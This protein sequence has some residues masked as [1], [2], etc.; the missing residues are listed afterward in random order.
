MHKRLAAFLNARAASQFDKFGG[1][2]TGDT[3]NLK[4][5]DMIAWGVSQSGPPPTGGGTTDDDDVHWNQETYVE[6]AVANDVREFFRVYSRYTKHLS[7]S[8][9]KKEQREQE[10]VAVRDAA[11]LGR[12]SPAPRER[13]QDRGTPSPSPTGISRTTSPGL[14]TEFDF[15]GFNTF[16]HAAAH[17]AQNDKQ[18]EEHFRNKTTE[19]EAKKEQAGALKA[20]AQ[21]VTGVMDSMRSIQESNLAF[22]E[23]MFQQLNQQQAQM[24]QQQAQSNA[25][26]AKL[27]EKL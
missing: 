20:M 2:L 17:R 25:L 10:G 8:K 11:R 23:K 5:N 7:E 3:L 21:T 19:A 27:L 12:N 22:Q 24:N 26:F 16:L 4:L 14:E 1:V 15:H 9:D 6:N 13:N 18:L